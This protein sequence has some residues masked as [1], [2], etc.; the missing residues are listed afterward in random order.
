MVEELA[1]ENT[2]GVVAILGNTYTGQTK[3][4]PVFV[5]LLGALVLRIKIQRVHATATQATLTM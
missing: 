5:L 1:D 2:I 3:R 4:S